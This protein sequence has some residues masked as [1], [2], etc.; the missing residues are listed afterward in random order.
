MSKAKKVRF[1]GVIAKANGGILSRVQSLSMDSNLNFTEVYEL[2]NPNI[3]QY[4]R[5]TPEVNITINTNDCASI[6]NL[7]K[8][9]DLKTGV[10]ELADLEGKSIGLTVL[11]EQDNVL[12]RSFVSANCYLAGLSWNYDVGG[13]A[14]ENY[15][16]TTDNKTAF[17]YTYRQAIILPVTWLGSGVSTAS[18]YIPS[19]TGLLETGSTSKYYYGNDDKSI[20]SIDGYRMLYVWNDN[21][22]TS[23][24]TSTTI[25]EHSDG[26]GYVVWSGENTLESGNRIFLVAYRNTPSTT[27]DAYS[28]ESGIASVRKGQVT[29]EIAP[30][31]SGGTFG[32]WYRVQTCGLDVDL[33][34]TALD[35]LG[36]HYSYDRSLP[37]P[38]VATVN[39]SMLDSDLEAFYEG[40]GLTWADTNTEIDVDDYSRS[41]AIRIRV[42]TSKDRLAGELKK[43]ILLDNIQVTTDS[44]SV[45]VQDNAKFNMTATTSYVYISGENLA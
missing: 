21:N 45:D 28:T 37:D 24:L 16:L 29:I 36:N 5:A 41:A 18:G 33:G 32:K 34:R 44:F 13:I 40:A 43:E 31:G 19:G 11:I 38:I 35:E 25:A 30:T 7:R 10:I 27:I 26:G 8:I 22:K 23:I 9:T 2:G 1:T 15:T 3:V 39:I 12:A 6:F 42:Y 17:S 4:D 14:S 20:Y